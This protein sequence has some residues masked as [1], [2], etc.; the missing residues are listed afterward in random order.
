MPGEAWQ[1][2]SPTHKWPMTIQRAQKLSPF[3]PRAN[4]SAVQFMLQSLT[5]EIQAMRLETTSLFSAL[6]FSSLLLVLLQVSSE[7][8][9]WITYVQPGSGSAS[10]ETKRMLS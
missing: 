9:P 1:V 8:T 3:A 4:N 5:N 6:P 10:K 2:N 7:N